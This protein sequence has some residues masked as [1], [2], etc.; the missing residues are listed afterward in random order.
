VSI[1]ERIGTPE[2]RDV[3]RHVATGPPASRLTREAT[4]ALE[5]MPK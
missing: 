3:V 2:A 5:R 4:A 1:L